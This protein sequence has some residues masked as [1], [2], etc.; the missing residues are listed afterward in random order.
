[1]LKLN[2]DNCQ[3]VKSASSAKEKK[4]KNMARLNFC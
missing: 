1:M 2:Y 4:N 3:W